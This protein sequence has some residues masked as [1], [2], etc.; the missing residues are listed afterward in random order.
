M[1]FSF[2]SFNTE[3]HFNVK[4]AGFEYVSLYDLDKSKKYVIRG[5]YFNTKGLFGE[6]AV[7]ALDNCLVNIPQ[8]LVEKCH[9]IVSSPQA[10][11]AINQ[12]SAGFTVREYESE[13]FNKLCRT[14]NF[15]D[16][17]PPQPIE[18]EDAEEN[19]DDDYD[20]ELS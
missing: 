7:F 3:V 5:I 16:I 13:K 18:V 12:G 20:F 4:T 11:Y 9:E 2:N 10:I 1:A 14:V 15:C 17:I 8:H 6:E 19:E